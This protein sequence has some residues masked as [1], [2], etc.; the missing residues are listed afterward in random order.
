M[1]VRHQIEAVAFAVA[2]AV[3]RA[4]PRAAALE[5][6][7]GLGQLTWWC[8]LRRR[9]VLENLEHLGEGE[10]VST[11]DRRE[12]GARAA[13][14][15]G[16]TFVEFLRF[17]GRDRHHVNEMI[18]VDGVEELRAALDEGKGAVV[19]T[20]HFG[21]WALYVT[22]LAAE[23]IEM[24][25]IIARQRNAAMHRM[26]MALPDG[27]VRFIPKGKSAPRGVLANL[28]E[29]RAVVIVADHYHSAETHWVPF[30][31]EPASTLPLP[32]AVVVRHDLP[33][34]LMTGHRVEGGR[35][36]VQVRRLAVPTEGDRKQREAGVAR[37][38]N[39]ALGEVILEDPS[40]YFWYHRRWKRRGGRARRLR[41]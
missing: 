2:S 34:F 17:P 9:V 23:G 5:V 31:G 24:A 13:R 11:S 8:G 41:D 28:K 35:H 25:Q 7:A 14:N 30:L 36:R 33:L 19:A 16:R 21:S 1:G 10:G 27:A 22:A 15:I 32:G 18:E 37:Q 38:I 39:D 20:G 26:I 29:G 3:L 6:G 40:H 4:L 12:I